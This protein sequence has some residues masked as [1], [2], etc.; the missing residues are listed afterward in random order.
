MSKRARFRFLDLPIVVTRNVLSTMD[1]F[2]IHHSSETTLMEM[3][4][5]NVVVAVE[6]CLQFVISPIRILSHGFKQQLVKLSRFWI[7]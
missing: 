4:V 2:D 5:D 1:P 7:A 3:I 6:H